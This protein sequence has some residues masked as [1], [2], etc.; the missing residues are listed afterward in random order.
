MNQSGFDFREYTPMYFSESAEGARDAY[1]ECSKEK[2]IEY[3]S[4]RAEKGEAEAQA[5]YAWLYLNKWISCSDSAKQAYNLAQAP[6]ELGDG[7]AIWISAWALLEDGRVEG[8]I[9][10]MITAAE[11]NFSP[12]VYNLG[13]LYWNGIAVQQDRALGRALFEFG[14]S[15]GHSSCVAMLDGLA[16][17]GV[18]GPWQKTVYYLERPL[19]M[20]FR[21]IG[22]WLSRKFSERDL[23][24]PRSYKV[25]KNFSG[26]NFDDETLSSLRKKLDYYLGE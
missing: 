2:F 20:P 6:R 22:W 8:G 24:F 10:E 23:L 19:V 7:F 26:A 16:R 5:I 18:F 12:A 13:Y 3:V 1:I 15:L 11:K 25:L 14:A 9:A 17:N 4:S 21:T